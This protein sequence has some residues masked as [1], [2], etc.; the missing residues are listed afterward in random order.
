MPEPRRLRLAASHDPLLLDAAAA[1]SGV[2]LNVAGSLD[3]L[4]LLRAGGVDSAGYHFGARYPAP[5]PF[6]ALFREP[7]IAIYPLFD[8]EQGFMLPPAIRT[9][10]RRSAT[11]H[12]SNCAS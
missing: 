3:A 7:G 12:G 6:D 8:R 2:E 5:A 4:A 11:S 10:W 1:V 9:A